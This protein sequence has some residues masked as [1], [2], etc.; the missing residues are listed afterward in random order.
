MTEASCNK[1]DG[2]PR[3]ILDSRLGGAGRGG[4]DV[5]G[6]AGFGGYGIIRKVRETILSRHQ[7]RLSPTC[8]S[9]ASSTASP[10][11]RSGALA[12]TVF[13]YKGQLRLFLLPFLIGSALLVVLP[14]IITVGLAFTQYNSIQAPTWTGLDN[15]Q[16]LFNSPL[17]R[18]SMRNSLAFLLV[19][20]PL[21]LIGA[22][23]IALLLQRPGRS[24]G[25][26]RAGVYLPTIIPEGAYAL[27]WLWI[28]NPL[29]G[30]LNA[31]LGGLG[32]PTPD[33]LIQPE[34][35]QMSFV[36][37][38][39]LTIGEGIIV[40]LVGLRTIPGVLYEAARVD[41][42]GRWQSFWRITLPVLDSVAGAADLSRSCGGTSKHLHA[43]L[44]DDLRRPL[45][46]H[47]LCTTAAL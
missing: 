5:M 16:R 14:A 10:T 3:Q 12:R 41:G 37:M 30:P 35:A 2:L 32:L 47:D 31:V 17:A 4:R 26:M 28:L 45:L 42:A 20:V 6:L 21:R 44:C 43:F 15:F 39:L 24:Y 38:S 13:S 46:R 29:Y 36:M 27:I 23:G 33:W 19:A 22:L 8:M 11:A 25:L 40:A 18:L 1:P 34:T 7:S 9:S